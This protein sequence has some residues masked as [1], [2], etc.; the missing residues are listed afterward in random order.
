MTQKVY[1]IYEL[2]NDGLRLNV[3]TKSIWK[4]MF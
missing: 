2:N 1:L 3:T 4:K